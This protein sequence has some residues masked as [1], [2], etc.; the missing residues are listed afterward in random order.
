MHTYMYM[1]VSWPHKSR[2]GVSRKMAYRVDSL[3]KT[4]LKAISGCAG[5]WNLSSLRS[6]QEKAT[7]TMRR[8]RRRRR[9][10]MQ[11]GVRGLTVE[12]QRASSTARRWDVHTCLRYIHTHTHK[13]IYIYIYIH[14]KDIYIYIDKRVDV[15]VRLKGLLAFLF[16][17]ISLVGYEDDAIASYRSAGVRW[18]KSTT[19]MFASCRSKIWT[20]SMWP[21]LAAKCNGVRPWPLGWF[22]NAPW[23]S[24]SSTSC[25]QL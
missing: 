11:N 4:L 21:R 6:A 3:S 10:R 25:S 18:S 13:Y 12:T 7:T 23:D 5:H 2:T 14:A 16:A 19:S 22:T 9:M 17:F 1:Y 8:M 20:I 15:P 24:R